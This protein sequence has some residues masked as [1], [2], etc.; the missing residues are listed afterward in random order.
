MSR[1][2]TIKPE[3]ALSETL[4]AVSVTAALLFARLP[5]FADDKGR[6]RYSPALIKAQVFPLRGEITQADCG[7]A[8]EELETM[9]LVQV[10]TVSGKTYLSIPGF[11]EHQ[12]VNRPQ[13]SQ[14]PPPPSIEESVD[15]QTDEQIQFSDDSLNTHGTLTD[16]SLNNHG[17]FSESESEEENTPLNG[18]D[19][20]F[21]ER[22]LNTHGAFTERSVTERKGREGNRNGGER[23][24]SNK[25]KKDDAQDDCL[26][27]FPILCL[28]EF[29][30]IFG[31]DYSALPANAARTLERLQDKYSID[32]VRAMLI[33]M[34]NQWSGTKFES[35]LT[36]KKLFGSDDFET[37]MFQ[38]KGKGARDA[39]IGEYASV[40]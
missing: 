31:R 13:E 37:Y 16:D 8:I 33:Y 20:S 38:S 9:K 36:P 15:D 1:I 3:S 24:E 30:E 23:K 18:D 25:E 26:P 14:Y 35:G 32:E 17:A 10:Y 39:D 11:A 22:S 27:P 28:R 5:C 34:K 21:T 19:S 6:M 40:L 7:A 4:E 2:R 12:K 29:N